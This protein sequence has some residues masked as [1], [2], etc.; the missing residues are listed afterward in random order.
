MEYLLSQH[1]PLPHDIFLD[2]TWAIR[3]LSK[4]GVDVCNVAANNG[5]AAALMKF[6]GNGNCLECARFLVSSGWDLSLRDS[7]GKTA[8]HF[9]VLREDIRTLLYLL[10][11][12][13]SL[14]PDV[15]L[16]AVPSAS[17][18]KAQC[19]DLTV[20]LVHLLILHGASVNITAPNGDTPLHLALKLRPMQWHPRD[21]PHYL[22]N[23]NG[24]CNLVKILLDYG[25]DPYAR[26][27]DGETPFELAE[28][29]GRFF[30]DNFLR[31]VRDT[32]VK[33]P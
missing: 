6:I 21:L 12:G 5:D 19:T 7:D 10:S 3:F 18:E 33:R 24:L 14:P 2:S 31:L 20:P 16:T 11:Q 9:V 13:V 27:A 30:K 23:R 29:G 25:S 8:I 17:D 26:N 1:I 4:R 28:A 32:P 15:L 22:G